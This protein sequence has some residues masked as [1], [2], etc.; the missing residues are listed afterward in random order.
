[1]YRRGQIYLVDKEND[2]NVDHGR[3]SRHTE[4]NKRTS[5]SQVHDSGIERGRL[6]VNG[7]YNSSIVLDYM[8]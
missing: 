8:D 1:M 2:W 7:Q 4:R 6:V 3:A 5:R